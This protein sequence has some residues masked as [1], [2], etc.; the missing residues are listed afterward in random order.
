MV[1]HYYNENCLR[2]HRFHQ[3][4]LTN[5][6]T[7]GHFC[8]DFVVYEAIDLCDSLNES[9]FCASQDWSDIDILKNVIKGFIFGYLHNSWWLSWIIS[10]WSRVPVW[11]STDLDSASQKL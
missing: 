8:R 11:H 10:K 5:A 2:R 3:S 7:C 1:L 6:T 9:N 4:E